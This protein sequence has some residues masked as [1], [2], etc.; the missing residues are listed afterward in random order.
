MANLFLCFIFRYIICTVWC[1]CLPEIQRVTLM[2]AGTVFPSRA[3][4]FTHFLWGSC[5]SIFTTAEKN[6]RH[7]HKNSLLWCCCLCI[8]FVT[9]L[10]PQ[11]KKR[12]MNQCKNVTEIEV[13]YYI[14]FSVLNLHSFTRKTFEQFT[15]IEINNLLLDIY[16]NWQQM[17]LQSIEN[18]NS[19]I[20]SILV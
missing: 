4:E 14:I 2:G 11:D 17:F 5:C 20:E 19:E 13:L 18:V 7:S 1:S 15:K 10:C 6:W 8:V 16:L 12:N 3:T 9:S